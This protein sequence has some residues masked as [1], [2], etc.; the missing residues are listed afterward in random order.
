V[1]L[2]TTAVAVGA[3]VAG[4]KVGTGVDGCAATVLE[5]A[6]VLAAA[7][8]PATLVESESADMVGAAFCDRPLQLAKAMAAPIT[9]NSNND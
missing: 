7:T 3:G 8:V 2:L 6:A 9:V 1:G 4:S 5:A